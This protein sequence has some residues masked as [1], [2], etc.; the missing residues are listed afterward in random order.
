MKISSAVLFTF[1][2]VFVVTGAAFAET[3]KWKDENGKTYFGD[4]VPTK[5]ADTAEIVESKPLNM[6]SPEESVKV[7][8]KAAADRLRREDAMKNSARKSSSNE[9]SNKSSEPQKKTWLTREFCRD[10]YVN[11]KARTE[12]FH[13]VEAQTKR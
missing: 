5:Y 12:C 4:T 3:Y 11:T 7:Q 10:T 13:E 6:I 8:N 1:A 9:Q 2:S